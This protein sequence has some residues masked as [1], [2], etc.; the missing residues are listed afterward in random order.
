MKRLSFPA[1]LGV[2]LALVFAGLGSPS[3]AGSNPVP[4]YLKADPCP[5]ASLCGNFLTSQFKGFGKRTTNFQSLPNLTVTRAS[6]AYGENADGS[7]RGFQ[8]GQARTTSKGLGVFEATTNLVTWSQDLSNAAWSPTGLGTVLPTAI[9]APD[10][11][12]TGNKLPE[13]ASNGAHRVLAATTKAA[14]A[15]TYTLSAYFKAAERS[16]VRLDFDDGG[17]N[18]A[19]AIFDA[20]TGTVSTPAAAS[21]TFTSP[22]AT[23]TPAANGWYRATLT[24]TTNTATTLRWVTNVALAG[25]FSY[26]GVAGNGVY[27]WGEDLRAGAYPVPYCP[28]TSSTATCAADQ[29]SLAGV[30]ISQTGTFTASY[31][32]PPLPGASSVRSYVMSVNDSGFARLNIRANDVSGAVPVCVV[33]DGASAPSLSPPF[34]APAGALVRIGCSWTATTAAFGSAGVPPATSGVGLAASLTGPQ[35]INLGPGGS[36]NIN[37]YITG[38]ALYPT[39]FSSAQIQAATSPVDTS[40]LS[41]NFASGLYKT[42]TPYVRTNLATYSQDFTQ[43]GWTKNGSVTVTAAA[44]TAPDGTTTAQ[45]LN[46]GNAA[47]ASLGYTPWTTTTGTY[48]FALDAKAGTASQVALRLDTAYD[49]SFAGAIFDTTACTFV[50][51]TDSAIN[52]TA[53]SIGAGWCRFSVTATQ[54]SGTQ[55]VARIYIVKNGALSNSVTST[56][57]VLIWGAQPE[58]TNYPTSYVYTNG[59]VASVATTQSTNPAD[60]GN[61]SYTGPAGY[62]P[63]CNGNLVSFAANNPRITCAGVL[64]EEARTNLETNTNVNPASTAGLTKSGDAAAVLSVVS[65]TAMGL[66][67]NVY[68]FDCTACS[69]TASA[70][71]PSAATVATTTYTASVYARGSGSGCATQSD[72]GC[73]PAA[74]P[75]T[76][77]RLTRTGAASTTGDQGGVTVAA[78][79][80]M[81]FTYN[82]LEAGAFA[83]SPIAVAGATI[84]RP[85]DV[86]AYTLPTIPT[87]FG[88]AIQT[89]KPPADAT[90]NKT[91]VNLGFNGTDNNNRVYV[92]RATNGFMAAEQASGGVVSYSVSADFS[93]FTNGCAALSYDGTTYHAGVLGTSFAAGAAARPTGSSYYMSI[94]SRL[95]GSVSLNTA[96]QKVVLFPYGA[97]DNEAQYRSACNF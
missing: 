67:G 72:L 62:A 47:F 53:Q 78:G 73:T 96:L 68:K 91:V 49:T 58:S 32:M 36:A 41:L 88:L 89:T 61:L 19:A 76:Y 69:G 42:T 17:S 38:F 37:S 29:I 7:L 23:I 25:S 39:A 50:G 95:D 93:S 20:S 63:D 28:T 44:G 85:A 35:T 75:S 26:Q 43:A 30:N 87:A 21:G 1:L 46:G 55:N 79:G 54:A 33:G 12:V 71:F 77:G 4:I 66:T 56:D 86:M 74:L 18:G 5:G 80:V 24:A 84:T 51:F 27:V 31:Y 11:T 16:Q 3:F 52:Y 9:A 83:T 64:I 81:F 70:F 57:N 13:D 10:G 94:G 2:V 45:R 60:V 22:S 6:F 8:A 97:N 14:S 40:S 15:I 92:Y 59:A 65:D 90:L 34:T 82:Q 48:T